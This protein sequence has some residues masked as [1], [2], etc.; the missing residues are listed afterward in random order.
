MATVCSNQGRQIKAWLPLP[1]SRCNNKVAKKADLLLRSLSKEELKVPLVAFLVMLRLLS[2]KLILPAPYSTRLTAPTPF[3]CFLDS[4]FSL[5]HSIY[6]ISGWS[7]AFLYIPSE[8]AL[9]GSMLRRCRLVA[10]SFTG[11]IQTWDQLHNSCSPR[12]TSSDLSDQNT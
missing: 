12:I 2:G 1:D 7:T 5:S 11:D 10:A 9:D 6:D 8:S 3:S 4:P